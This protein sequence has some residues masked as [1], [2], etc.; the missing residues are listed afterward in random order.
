LIRSDCST[1]CLVA[2]LEA[3]ASRIEWANAASFGR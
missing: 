3:H 2:T 1:F